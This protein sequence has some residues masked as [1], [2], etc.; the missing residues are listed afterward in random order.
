MQNEI[1]T[2][3]RDCDA[4]L[5]PAGEEIKLIKGTRVRI[6][7]ALG[8]DYTLFVNGNLVKISGQDADAIGLEPVVYEVDESKV[9][10][11]IPVEKDLVWDQLKTVFDPEIPVNI[12]DLGLIYDMNIEHMATGGSFVN[13]KMTLTAPGCGMGPM[14]AQD[15]QNKVR[16]VP[17]VLDVNVNLVW[18]PQWD[19]DMMTDE[20]RLQ[21]GML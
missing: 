12:V 16:T 7:Q 18:E 14:I 8:G 11:S 3:T 10:L 1:I 6:T 15:A 20:A 9:D 5:I 4:T 21:M 19:R 13:I 2:V 17:G